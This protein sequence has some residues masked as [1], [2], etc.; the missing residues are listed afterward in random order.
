MTDSNV[1]PFRPKDR[2]AAERKRR[3]RAKQRKRRVTPVAVTPVTVTTMFGHGGGHGGMSQRIDDVPQLGRSVAVRNAARD[4]ASV[5]VAENNGYLAKL[6]ALEP[7]GRSL[8]PGAPYDL[9]SDDPRAATRPRRVALVDV[10]AY[11]VA[12]GLA[13]CAAW[14]SLKGLA[15][16]FPGAP[17][18]IV[19]MGSMM[20][21]AKLVACGWLARNWRQV[22]YSF[23][24]ILM[25]L[26]AGL[27]V[28]NAG[29][30][31]SQLTAAHVG[32]R[33]MT[34]ATRTMQGVDLD[35]RIEVAAGKLNDLDRRIA[36]ID[37]I[38]AGAAQRG[39]A[40]TAASIM[41]DQRKDRAALVSERQRAA[42][43]LAALKMERGGV[44]ARATIA[45][46]E[47]M[48]IMYAAELL[49][50]G[51]DSE[52]AIRWLIALLV[53]CLDPMALALTAATSARRRP[54][55]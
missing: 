41:S 16:L 48:P 25:A 55:Q 40:N 20:E 38:V 8:R 19:V 43:A 34:A 30:T 13:G 21:A 37:G 39:W 26:I 4:A 7:A 49:G 23:R 17:I 32:D 22:P 9:P 6:V 52:R 42:E 28:I 33:A 53:C 27:A 47:M 12:V 35:Q 10:L 15:V 36:A 24:G 54:W 18:A 1:T 44:Q 45:E 50:I 11:A 51:A 29:G 31:F 46:S 14:F 3:S 2:T 5:T